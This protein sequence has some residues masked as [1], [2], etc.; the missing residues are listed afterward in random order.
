MPRRECAIIA[1]QVGE[2]G[3]KPAPVRPDTA[4]IMVKVP[5]RIPGLKR[6]QNRC[7][8]DERQQ[9]P[10][11][12]L[13]HKRLDRPRLQRITRAY[14]RQNKKKRHEPWVDQDDAGA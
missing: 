14:P 5:S 7:P 2:V 11:G 3:E 4:F 13:H 10:P 12:S 6:R 8:N 1:A 9:Q